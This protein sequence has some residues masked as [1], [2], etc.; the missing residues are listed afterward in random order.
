MA[1]IAMIYTRASAVLGSAER[2]SEWLRTAHPGLDGQTPL[3]CLDR[4]DGSAAVLGLLGAI[5]ARQ[6]Q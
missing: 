4:D 1:M 6:T 2:T 3:D 5:E